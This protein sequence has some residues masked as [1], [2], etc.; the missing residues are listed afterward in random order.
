MVG[1]AIATGAL[2]GIGFWAP[3]FYERHADVG[4]DRRPALAG[5]IILVGALVGTVVGGRVAT[6][7]TFAYEGAPMLSRGCRSSSAP[8]SSM[9]TFLPVPLWVRMPAQVIGVACIS[10]ACPACP[11]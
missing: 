6:G 11:P 1:S 5:G 8:S 10:A 2:A 4:A 3:A 7:Y 9:P